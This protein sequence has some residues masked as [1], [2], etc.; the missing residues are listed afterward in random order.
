MGADLFG[1]LA[2]ATCAA[3][4]VGSTSTELITTTDAMYF[5]LMITAVG[6]VVSFITQFFAVTFV[7]ATM[8]NVEKIIKWQLIISTILMTGALIPLVDFLPTTFTIAD[9][10][11]T[12]Y[13]AFLCVS[14]GL[15]SG[16]IIGYV[17]ELYTSNQYSP[18]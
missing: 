12:P 8:D 13:H 11:V 9:K 14:F 18:V 17:T 6:I 1:S 3:L 15:W 2:E 10:T 4:V 16:L 7:K 5:P